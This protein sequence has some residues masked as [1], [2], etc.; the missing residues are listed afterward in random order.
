MPRDHCIAIERA[1]VEHLGVADLVLEPDY[2]DWR[3]HLGHQIDAAVTDRLHPSAALQGVGFVE[4]VPADDRSFERIAVGAVRV[5]T[6]GA[7]GIRS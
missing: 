5:G 1:D 7:P 4:V 6:F 2:R 3:P